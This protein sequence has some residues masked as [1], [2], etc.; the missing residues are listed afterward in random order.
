MVLRDE[1]IEGVSIIQY[2]ND[3]VKLEKIGDYCCEVIDRGNNKVSPTFES[4]HSVKLEAIP[5]FNINNYDH[6]HSFT[7]NNF[8]YLIMDDGR[9]LIDNINEV[10]GQVVAD[11]IDT[12]VHLIQKKYFAQRQEHLEID[13]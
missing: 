10:Q 1:L 13:I 11:N 3:L 4:L 7:N 6:I 9:V 5:Q 12:P 2:L 8:H